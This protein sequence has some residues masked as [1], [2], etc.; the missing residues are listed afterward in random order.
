LILVGVFCIVALFAIVAIATFGG[1]GTSS[2][3]SEPLVVLLHRGSR[4]I[5]VTNDTR[6][7]RDTFDDCSIE[8]AGRYEAR[9]PVFKPHES[10][11]INY[12]DFIVGTTNLNEADRYARA[13]RSVSL[14]CSDSQSHQRR[15]AIFR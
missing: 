12:S 11:E 14:S 9:F 13:L 7:T 2:T 5:R 3:S 6:D 15:D 10:V 4:G 8:L 1:G